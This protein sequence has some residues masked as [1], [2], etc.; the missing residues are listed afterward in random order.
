MTLYKGENA[1]IY[2]LH[3]AGGE[4]LL[5][6]NATPKGWVLLTEAIGSDPHAPGG[7]NYTG[8]SNQ[9]LGVI[10]RLNQDYGPNGTIPREEF[11]PQFG[12][13]C[14]NFVA[15]SQGAHI[16]V[17]GN[18]MNFEREQPRQA[19]SNLAEPITPRRYAKCYKMV[20]A[21]IKSVPGHEKDLVVVG[22]IGP[23]NGQ[24]PYEAA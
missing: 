24:T 9:G 13:R 22:A 15:G 8:I 19:G 20:R 21:K 6:D 17:L 2:G 12:Q 14:A 3:D 5:V 16:W 18:E 11:Y 23:W 4:H 10:V 7:G 1:Y